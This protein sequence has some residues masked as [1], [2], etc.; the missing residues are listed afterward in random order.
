MRSSRIAASNAKTTMSD[1]RIHAGARRRGLM[2]QP[3]R[4]LRA[5]GALPLRDLQHALA[6]ER[7]EARYQPIVRMAD[8][9]LCGVEVLARLNHP[10]RGTVLPDHFVPQMEGAGL[11][12]PLLAAITACGLADMADPRLAPLDLGIAFNL[13]LDALLDD[14]VL[15][16]LQSERRQA[17]LD[18][19]RLTIELTENCHPVSNVAALE[20]AL[21]RWHA[22]GF[23]VSLDDITPGIARWRDLLALKFD[24]V[25]LDR[26]VVTGSAHDGR[27]RDFLKELIVRAH[28]ADITVVA[29]GLES[30]RDWGRMRRL[31][32]DQAQGFAIGRPMPSHTLPSW[33]SGWIAQG[34][35]PAIR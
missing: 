30:N 10:S 11:W 31:D 1:S 27:Q 13:P 18:G 33:L 20:A 35:A 9:A 14:A 17:G 3:A 19:A 21:A 29:E 24:S 7:F 28:R 34:R 32:V 26:S 4:R 8:G 2:A 5:V 25:K 22:G 12:R 16:A 6:D 23:L 15:A